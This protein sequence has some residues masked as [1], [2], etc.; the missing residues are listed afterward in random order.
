MRWKTHKVKKWPDIVAFIESIQFGFR[1][2]G[3]ETWKW[4]IKTDIYSGLGPLRHIQMIRKK[5]FTLKMCNNKSRSTQEVL[6]M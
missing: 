1:P 4:D 2:S 3:N 6:L 5:V